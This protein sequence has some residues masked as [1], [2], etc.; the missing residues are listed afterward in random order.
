MADPI[1]QISSEVDRLRREAKKI[2]RLRGT[3]LRAERLEACLMETLDCFERMAGEFRDRVEDFRLVFDVNR[4]MTELLDAD[5]LL[6][7]MVRLVAARMDVERCSVMLMDE[8]GQNLYVKVG[9]GFDRPVEELT[10]TRVG[11]GISGKV[12]ETGE[13]L[14]IK[15][16]ATDRRFRKQKGR[17]YK[18]DS[19]LCVPLKHKGTV[20]GVLNV[21]NKR[22]GTYFTESDL[23]L[24]SILAGAAAVSLSNAALHRQTRQTMR[25]LNNVVENIDTGLMAVDAKGRVALLNRAFKRLFQMDETPDRLPCP[26]R[27]LLPE[28][29]ARYFQRIIDRTWRE[30]DQRDVEVDI[31]CGKG[32]KLPADVGSLLLRDESLQ[33]QSQLV[34]VHDLSQSRELVKLRQLDTMKDNFISTVS[35]E[36]RTPLTSMLASLSLIQQGF[37]GEVAPPQAELLTIIRRNAERLK[38]LINDLLDLSRLESGRTQINLEKTDLNRL[39]LDCLQDI[40]HLAEE[41]KIHLGTD[42]RFQGTIEI[43][44]MKIQQVMI[45]L[46]GNGLKFTPEG[47]SVTVDTHA[48]GEMALIRVRD[49]GHGI[50]EEHLEKIF[51]R[52]YQV[53]DAMTRSTTGTGLGLPICKR[54]VEMHG[55]T[56]R[57]ESKVGS[58]SCFEVSLPC[59][60]AGA[61]HK[62]G[63]G[64]ESKTK[65]SRERKRPGQSRRKRS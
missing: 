24:L 16:I 65:V 11:Q 58:G 20:I 53:E 60:A 10:P 35:H 22:D 8:A 41:K 23:D 33:F 15:N 54:I 19:L 12:A 1:S 63:V 47:G 43:D 3:Q 48:A 14:L 13:P 52:F 27:S 55:G 32:R 9:L 29:A 4:S 39:V 46:L 25:Y 18:N 2:L 49:T 51:N 59:R 44:P 31:D 57:V 56:I 17:N 5:R 26:L 28:G 34:I 7:E 62:A 6:P 50:P 42:L 30:G 61:V 40:R 36:L 64:P 21:N 45:N 37:V 38:A